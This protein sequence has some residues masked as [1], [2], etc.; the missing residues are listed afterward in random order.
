MMSSKLPPQLSPYMPAYK[1]PVL[2]L[3]DVVR[4]R[5]LWKSKLTFA[6][7]DGGHQEFIDECEF[8]VALCELAIRQAMADRDRRAAE[9]PQRNEE[10]LRGVRVVVKRKKV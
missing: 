9:M 3:A 1:V 7:N 4:V 10:R 5:D 6:L 8:M 2:D